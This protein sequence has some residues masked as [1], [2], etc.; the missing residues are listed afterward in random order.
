MAVM[1]FLIWSSVTT[2]AESVALSTVAPTVAFCARS[3]FT[4][5]PSKPTSRAVPAAFC[6]RVPLSSVM[7]SAMVSVPL[8][9]ME[10]WLLTTA[11]SRS[12]WE[13]PVKVTAEPW[14][15]LTG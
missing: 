12:I 9:E 7:P 15:T 3:R 4:F 13:F 11:P 8:P 5:R 1:P 14:P 6:T 2:Q 10:P